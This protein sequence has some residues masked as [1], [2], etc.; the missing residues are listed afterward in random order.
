MAVSPPP[1]RAR[2]FAATLIAPNTFSKIASACALTSSCGSTRAF[3]HSSIHTCRMLPATESRRS[4]HQHFRRLQPQWN[5]RDSQGP[6]WWASRTQSHNSRCLMSAGQSSANAAHASI[7]VGR[8]ASLPAVFSC[9]SSAPFVL[10]GAAFSLDKYEEHAAR[11][12]RLA[13]SG[14][15]LARRSIVLRVERRI[16]GKEL[17][18]AR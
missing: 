14:R 1:G 2:T 13:C 9:S 12:A 7:N 5:A 11:M 17:S 4:Q 18:T 6:G 16:C 15:M 8:R 3:W 10:V